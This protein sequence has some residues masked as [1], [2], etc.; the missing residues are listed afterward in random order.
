MYHNNIAASSCWDSLEVW[1]FLGWKGRTDPENESIRNGKSLDEIDSNSNQVWMHQLILMRGY[2][3]WLSRS[4]NDSWSA[5]VSRIMT[6]WNLMFQRSKIWKV[7]CWIWKI[8]NLAIEFLSKNVLFACGNEYSYDCDAKS[9][10]I[11]GSILELLYKYYCAS[12]NW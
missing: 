8:R 12:F 9:V 7:N 1:I 10:D 6:L 3:F 4:I 2:N 11:T 5:F